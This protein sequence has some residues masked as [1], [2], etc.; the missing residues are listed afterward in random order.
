MPG[1][2]AA[3][4]AFFS[5]TLPVIVTWA[6][7]LAVSK[8]ITNDRNSNILGLPVSGSFLMLFF[9]LLVKV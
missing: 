7:L 3:V 6:K 5:A 9:I 1:K 2:P 4:A 8:L